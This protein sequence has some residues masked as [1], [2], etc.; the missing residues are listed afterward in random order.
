MGEL[1]RPLLSVHRLVLLLSDMYRLIDPSVYSVALSV[2]DLGL[3][4]V[5]D[6]VERDRMICD[7]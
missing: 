3:I 4:P 1:V 7:C 6:V 5:Y 2:D